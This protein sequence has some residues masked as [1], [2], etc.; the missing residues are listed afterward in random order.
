MEDEIA[1][2]VPTLRNTRVICR[3]GDPTDLYDLAIVNPQSLALDHRPVAGRR[4]SGFAGHQVGAGAGQRSRPAPRALPHRRRDT[5]P[6]ERRGRARRR[7]LGG[8]AGARRRPDLAHR[9]AF[10]PAGGPE[11]RLFR[12]ARFRR[13][14]NLHRRT[15]RRL[16]ARS[17]DDA[18]MAYENCTLIG[19]CDRKGRVYLNPP[20]QLIIRK[21]IKAIIIAEDDAAIHADPPKAS[22]DAQ[23]IRAPKPVA[24]RSGADADPGLEPARPDHR[25]RAVALCRA[26]LAADDCRRHA[27][28][29]GGNRGAVASQRQSRRRIP[30]RRHHQPRRAGKPRRPRP[31]TTCWCWATA[32]CCRRSRPTRARW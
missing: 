5:R 27:R 3:S 7:R 12:A 23:T 25:P 22:F 8:P 26:G 28:P 1:A 17:F 18:V 13:L 14:R 24:R 21:G 31:T 6:Q 30:P 10:E 32:T 19:L 29:R 2:K 11:R 20:G 16:S 9:R 4:R 15:A